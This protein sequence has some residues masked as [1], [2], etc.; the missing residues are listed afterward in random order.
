MKKIR[1][2]ALLAILLVSFAITACNGD[3][4]PSDTQ[5]PT[6]ETTVNQSPEEDSSTEE[7]V[8][9][10]VS[11][12]EMTEPD[13]TRPSGVVMAD[14]YPT[15]MEIAYVESYT[16]KQT[17][18][19]DE[20]AVLYADALASVGV[21]TAED[22]LPL[23]VTLRD[24]SSDFAYGADE[25]YI[26]TIT[27]DEIT[28]EAQ[29]NRGVHYAF[30]TLLQIVED[31]GAFPLVTVK[32]A[33][34]NELRGVIEGFYGTAWTHEYRKE[35]F[36]FM[37]QNKMNA[38]IY[39]PKDD[40]KHRAQ[41]RS[42]YT[43][44]ELKRMTDLI[45]TANENHVKFIYAISPGGDIN[46]GSGYE[47]DFKKLMAKCEQ[48]YELGCRDFAIFL[49]DIPTLD[50]QGH[51]KLLN[52]F[53]AKFVDTHEGVSD[54]IAITTEYGDPFLTSYTTEI[55]PLIHK[56]VVLMWTGPGVI[57]ESIT[58]DSLKHIIKTY[59]RKVLI[60]WNY[61]VNDTLANHL[62]MGACVN[63]EDTLY[64]SIAG[65]TANP[66]NQGYASMVPLFTTGDY[67]WNPEAYNS[68][69]SLIAA[70]EA[71]MPDASNA[72][73]HFISMTCASGINKNTDSVAVKALLD[74]F[75]QSNTPE[76]RAALKA[77]FEEMTRNADTILTSS[78]TAMVDEIREWV[79]KY[80]VYGQMGTLYMTMEDA[81]AEGAD[82]DVLLKLLGEYKT[83]E[84]SI[85][86]NPRLVS[87][88]VLT[89][90]FTSLSSRFSVLL[91]QIE[92]I[93]FAPATPY[94]NCNTYE[95]YKPEYLLD[96]DDST[97]FWT[98]G[99]LNTAAGNKTGYFGVD[100]G[101]VIHVTNVFVATGVGGSDELKKGILEYSEDGK[102]WT[103]LY[104]G[105][106]GSELFLQGLD[107]KARYVRI[108][109]G[110]TTDNSWVKARAFE[111]NTNRV[112]SNQSAAGSP[113]WTT[114]LPTYQTYVPD[115]MMDRDENTYFWSGREGREGDY[116]QLD[117]GTVTHVT[118]IT[119]KAGVPAHA[120]DYINNG[121]LT[122]SVDGATW[123][124]ICAVNS[125]DTVKDVDI[126]ARYVRVTIKA[127]QTSWITV[128]EFS[129]VGE[130]NV[131]PLLALDTNDI[132]RTDL[133]TLTDGHYVSYFAPDDKKAKGKT[134]CV[135]VD[136]TGIVTLT[137][138]VLPED[139][140][141]V[142]VK[143]AAGEVIQTIQLHY[144]TRIEAPA[145]SVIHIPL[146]NSLMLAEVTWDQ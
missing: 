112:T 130:D 126:S 115:N 64:Q 15:P 57:P 22:G 11:A 41:W 139:G 5:A 46:L 100:L 14:V 78:N 68:E 52:D 82:I 45:E 146:G 42:L 69:K 19:P 49:D 38:Y 109:A 144:V 59:G 34:R 9:E 137:A 136:D 3:V 73:L 29:T 76:T 134:L 135:T 67:L 75:K 120:A 140:L 131:S 141:T 43:G 127:N 104:S 83:I 48:I 60:W 74:A 4:T 1:L 98:H 101:S 21:K 117:L 37:G 110:D 99:D 124:T 89:T 66:M 20:K 90:Y 79:E 128:S 70:C 138:L 55:A 103:V 94:T 36:A 102:T 18:K 122:Y 58:N 125:R 39:A 96:G 142:T 81:Y 93:S 111:V 26:L 10:S 65:L 40:A 105:T 87:A 97:Y 35:L 56:D 95:N 106:C 119:F 27:D 51:A 132:P 24:M 47:A 77:Y 6:D 80:R 91:G 28:I 129:A 61:P 32:D 12:D 53:Q 88:S 118:R 116:I 50:A 44:A 7:S 107:V 72:L 114:S 31:S 123:H 23:T 85:R 92:G 2:I 71:L 84:E 86:S 133:L 63:L 62:F 16:G 33:P 113:A 143:N 8:Q 30:M 54:L 25:A 121:E 108:R 145:G 13:E 17:I